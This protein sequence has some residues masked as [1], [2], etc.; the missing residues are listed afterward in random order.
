MTT[1]LYTTDRQLTDMWLPMEA[2]QTSSLAGNEAQQVRLED[3]M[4]CVGN[5]RHAG[6]YRRRL[7][8][9]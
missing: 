9:D 6:V 7:L 4:L 5:R 2:Q 8:C 1:R 3:E